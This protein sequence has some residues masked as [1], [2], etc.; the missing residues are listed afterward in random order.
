M[1][2]II[3]TADANILASGT[4]RIGPNPDAAPVRFI[5]AWET[6]RFNVVLSE[7]LLDEI[8]RTLTKRYFARW[9]RPAER[10]EIRQFL[11]RRAIITP[12]TV[13]VVGVATQPAD[14]LVLATALSGGAQYLVTGDYKLVRLKSYRGLIILNVNEF[15]ATLPGLQGIEET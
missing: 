5:L 6:N 9:V 7:H 2:E 1:N 14:D 11:E 3:V 13:P 10:V 8:D 12:I 15:L 4:A